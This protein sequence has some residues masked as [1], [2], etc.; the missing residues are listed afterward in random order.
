MDT[1]IG[2]FLQEV[3]PMGEIE[4]SGMFQHKQPLCHQQILFKDEIR[5]LLNSCKLVGRVGKNKIKLL[6]QRLQ[7]FED[8]SPDREKLLCAQLLLRMTDE[9]EM[10]LILFH[11]YHIG[12]AP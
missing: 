4:F 8:I 2:T 11:A 10:I 7:I 3:R 1:P 5:Q 12:A 9:V 6:S